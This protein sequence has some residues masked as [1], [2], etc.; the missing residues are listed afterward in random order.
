MGLLVDVTSSVNIAQLTWKE[1]QSGSVQS[2]DSLLLASLGG[3]KVKAK[4]PLLGAVRT[5]GG[6]RLTFVG[7]ASGEVLLEDSVGASKMGATAVCKKP[8]GNGSKK[9]GKE[10]DCTI[11]SISGLGKRSSFRANTQ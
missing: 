2:G 1:R 7:L 3:L 10:K 9:E 5:R 6:K 8:N 4:L 11:F